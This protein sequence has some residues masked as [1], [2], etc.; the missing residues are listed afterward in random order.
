MIIDNNLIKVLL[1]LNLSLTEYYVLQCFT[2][3]QYR[4]L[5]NFLE[6][7]SENLMSHGLILFSDPDNKY[8]EGDPRKYT[9]TPKGRKVMDQ[10]TNAIFLKKDS[11]TTTQ[12]FE[13]WWAEFPSFANH[14][15]FRARR[16]LK[17]NKTEAKKRYIQ[18][19]QLGITPEMLLK[20]LQADVA[21]RKKNST[22]YSNE[23][24]MIPS[25]GKWLYQKEYESFLSSEDLSSENNT[26]KIQEMHGKQLF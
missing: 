12:L 11:E 21:L 20:A 8:K 9:L 17:V 4:Y 18:T 26:E 7:V 14:G 24:E 1:D 3:K 16:R 22:Q 13:K 2:Y 25:P 6:E 23:L 10:C 15:H 5:T 19:L